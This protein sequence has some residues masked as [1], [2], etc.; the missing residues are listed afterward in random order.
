MIDLD[1][2]SEQPKTVVP[3]VVNQ[4]S[5]HAVPIYEELL[6]REPR[7]ALSEG[8]RHFE[9]DSAVFKALHKIAASLKE[10]GIPYAVVGGMACAASPRMSIFSSPNTTSRLSTRSSKGLAISRRFLVANISATRS[11][12]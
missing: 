4:V 12:A 7:L 8:S 1:D 5:T 9:E 2:R 11:P 3:D 6:N 10:I